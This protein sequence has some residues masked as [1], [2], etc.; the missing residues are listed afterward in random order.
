MKEFHLDV[1][2]KDSKSISLWAPADYVQ[3]LFYLWRKKGGNGF[4]GRAVIWDS[5]FLFVFL[6]LSI[7]K[8]ILSSCKNLSLI[9]D[10]SV[11]H[12]G[13]HKGNHGVMIW[14]TSAVTA[15]LLKNSCSNERK[16]KTACLNHHILSLFFTSVWFLLL[17]AQNSNDANLSA[18]FV[19]FL[20]A[21]ISHR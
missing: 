15:P 3:R 6:S 4:L 8:T 17:F 7:V 13:E 21:A 19:A 12:W 14:C 1:L 20:S 9:T 10:L 16:P 11:C 18:I 2:F 5:R